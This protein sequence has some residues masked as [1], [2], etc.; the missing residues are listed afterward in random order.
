M[1]QLYLKKDKKPIGIASEFAVSVPLAPRLE[2][3]IL[4]ALYCV[5]VTSFSKFGLTKSN[6]A[7]VTL[8]VQ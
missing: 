6:L 8:S 3:H 5:S 1:S 7:G 4:N 2:V